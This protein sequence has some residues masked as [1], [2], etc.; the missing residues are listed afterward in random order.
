MSLFKEVEKIIEYT[1]SIR[2]LEKYLSFDLVFPGTWSILKSQVD[3][4]KTVFHKNDEKGKTVS[5]L[6][7]I[8]EESISETISRIESVINFN[9]EKEEKQRLFNEK[10]S[11]LKNLF[12]KEGLDGL[13]SLK[14][15]IDETPRLEGTEESIS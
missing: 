8:N 5:L 1:N 14:F 12:E 7:E 13:K 2:K 10:V 9:K 3:E 4:S 15:D 11:E 6:S